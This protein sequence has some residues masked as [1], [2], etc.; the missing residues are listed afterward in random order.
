MRLEEAVA[1]TWDRYND[2][3]YEGIRYFSLLSNGF[4]EADVKT[5][6]SKRYVLL[7]PDLILPP[8]QRSGRL[9]TYNHGKLAIKLIQS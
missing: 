6:S 7:H 9:F 5:V 2:T 8:V 3:D 1:L 4:G